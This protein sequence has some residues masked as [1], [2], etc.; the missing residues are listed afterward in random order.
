MPIA[1]LHANPNAK[2]GTWGKAECADA[3]VQIASTV[4][5]LSKQLDQLWNLANRDLSANFD[6]S[7]ASPF[8]HIDLGLAKKIKHH[9]EML[10]LAADSEAV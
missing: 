4:E 2:P 6:A 8:D 10:Q 3:L 1:T 7:L 9:A 5:V